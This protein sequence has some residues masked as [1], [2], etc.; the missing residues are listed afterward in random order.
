MPRSP[1][2]W[3]G[4]WRKAPLPGA[5]EELPGDREGHLLRGGHGRHRR[6]RRGGR[7]R[8]WPVGPPGR[9][10]AEEGRGHHGHD[11]G[12][13]RPRCGGR[14]GWPRRHTLHPR[15]R[16]ALRGPRESGGA[17]GVPGGRALLLPAAAGPGGGRAAR[18]LGGQGRERGR[19]GGAVLRAVPGAQ[20]GAVV[21][22]A[23]AAGVHARV[24]RGRG[25]PARGQEERG[26][27]EADDGPPEPGLG[28]GGVQVSRH[29]AGRAGGG[30]R[31][32]EGVALR[33]D[34][35]GHR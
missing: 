3:Q 18:P 32:G 26:A 19:R 6:A 22:G 30:R 8:T 24:R 14:P 4:G 31:P 10:G 29:Q 15:R 21:R 34:Q 33:H 23:A 7:E 2:P 27:A 35:A 5:R 13:G 1:V 16:Q 20:R 12:P 9:A 11:C 25:V 28:H 17:R